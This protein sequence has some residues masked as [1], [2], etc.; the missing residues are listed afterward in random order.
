MSD[1]VMYL[2]VLSA[3]L[4][5]YTPGADHLPGALDDAAEEITRLRAEVARLRMTDAE[6]Q[7]LVRAAGW[8]SDIAMTRKDIHTAGYVV[9]DAATLRAIAERHGVRSPDRMTKA[10]QNVTEP[11]QAGDA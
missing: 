3:S 4:R 8:L 10:P 2:R 6:R 9:D 1:I 11:I 7:A 5:R